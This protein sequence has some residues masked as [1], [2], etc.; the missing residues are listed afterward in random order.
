LAQTVVKTVPFMGAWANSIDVLYTA[1]AGGGLKGKDR[2]SA[3]KQI[4]ITGTLLAMTTLAYCMMVSGDKDY[5][6]LDDDTKLRNVVIPGTSVMLPMNTGAGFGFFALTVSAYNYVTKHGTEKEVDRRRLVQMISR[7]FMDSHFGPE[8]VPSLIK[9]FIEISLK[10]NFFTGREI[11]PKSLENLDKAQQYTATTSEAGKYL[12]S[13]LSVAGQRAINPIEADHLIRSL[14]GSIGGFVQW[15]SNVLG[16]ASENRVAMSPKQ[17]PFVGAFIKPEVPRGNLDLFYDFKNVV[18]NKNSTFESYIR[19][20]KTEQAKAYG[21]ENEAI[22]GWYD[23]V[24]E[25]EKDINETNALIREIGESSDK[26]LTPKLKAEY[27]N[28]LQK[29]KNAELA[30]IE[31]IRKSANLPNIIDN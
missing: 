27:I 7:A 30:G 28:I 21:K 8:P 10:H 22:I 29:A 12:S 1:L 31:K 13:M 19:Q 3:I 26:K 2:A 6:E 9:P 11:T 20:G 16:E 17:Y 18:E 15:Y 4:A 24:Q 23:Y 25:M 5:E 14:T